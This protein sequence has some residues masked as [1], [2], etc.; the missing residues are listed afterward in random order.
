MGAVNVDMVNVDEV[1]SSLIT[2]KTI[3][4]L[5]HPVMFLSV[6]TMKITQL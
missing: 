4:V 1:Y 2:F 3:M 5:A 6:K